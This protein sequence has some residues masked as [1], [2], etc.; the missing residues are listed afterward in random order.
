MT[1]SR[2]RVYARYAI[3]A[4]ELLGTLIRIERKSRKMTVVDLSD[5][6]GVDR[7]TLQR[8]EQGDPKVELGLAFEACAILG[9]R[10][11]DEDANGLEARLEEV[12]KR[13]AL[14]PAR[15]RR[16]PPDVSDDF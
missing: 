2:K 15:I 9:L 11:F 5:R 14:L 8:L 16:A 6:L 4:A 13:A 12:G 7:G 1:A 3:A 10:L